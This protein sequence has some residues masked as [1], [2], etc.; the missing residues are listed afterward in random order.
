MI[1]SDK[2]LLTVCILFILGIILFMLLLE[3]K[4]L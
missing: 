2:I 4:I 3:W 1:L